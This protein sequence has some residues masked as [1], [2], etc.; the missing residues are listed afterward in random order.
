MRLKRREDY[1]VN[2][3]MG[4]MRLMLSGEKKKRKNIKKNGG[5]QF[6]KDIIKDVRRS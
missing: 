6:F 2:F 5:R 1:R 3:V 4:K